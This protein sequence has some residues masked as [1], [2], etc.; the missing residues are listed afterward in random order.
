MKLERIYFLKTE[1]RNFTDIQFTHLLSK[2]MSSGLSFLTKFVQWH[3]WYIPACGNLCRQAKHFLL[4]SVSSLCFLFQWVLLLIFMSN[5]WWYQVDISKIYRQAWAYLQLSKAE[6]G[7]L[8][9]R[10]APKQKW[11]ILSKA[12]FRVL[13][14]R[15]FFFFCSCLAQGYTVAPSESCPWTQPNP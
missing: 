1:E 6:G 11:G 14:H 15:F 8:S 9:L 5:T 10:V 12:P 13:S 7:G 2:T 4:Q 3:L